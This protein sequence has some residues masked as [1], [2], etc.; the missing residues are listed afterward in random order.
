MKVRPVWAV[1]AALPALLLAAV[2][3]A[4]PAHAT[5]T[6]PWDP[7]P[8]ANGTITFYDTTGH[9]VTGGSN[10]AHIADYAVASSGPSPAAATKASLYFATPQF[11]QPTGNFFADSGSA[12]STFPSAS[13]PA[14]LTGPAFTHPVVQIGATD[15]NLADHIASYPNNDTTD[16]GY[17][18]VYQVR[19]QDGGPGL[20]SD[21]KYWEAN[22]LVDT[23]A[24]TW[25]Q[26]NPPAATTLPVVSTPVVSGTARVG[27]TLSCSAT[28]TGAPT[29]TKTYAWS[30]NGSKISGATKSTLALTG[31]Y[32]NRTVTCTVTG[33]NSAGHTAKTS[34]GHKIALGSALKA[35]KK[36][37]LSGTFKSGRTV[38]VAHGT[39]TPAASSY[40][41]QWKRGTKSI[42]HATK[43]SYKLVKADKGKKITCTVTA[44][45]TGYASGHATTASKKVSGK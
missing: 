22:V 16:A 26:L 24:G 37:K 27:H 4:L 28:A 29:P 5:S 40:T 3:V 15:G 11:G 30:S 10:L 31:G 14:P 12:A 9:V 1:G 39:W 41:Y 42:K 33:T 8:N 2:V 23:V 19:L 20:L 13:Y 36:P 35:S 44:R 38:R 17:V 18:G 32:Y 43:S 25:T 45:R 6:P 34:A 21:G 7:D